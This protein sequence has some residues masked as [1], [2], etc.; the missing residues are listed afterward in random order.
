[1][2]LFNYKIGGNG[3][4]ALHLRGDIKLKLINI[5]F[6]PSKKVYF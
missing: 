3:G 1:M 5:T 4:K 6:I 2:I